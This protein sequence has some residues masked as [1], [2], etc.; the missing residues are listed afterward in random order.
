MK[1]IYDVIVVGSGAGGGISTHVLTQAGLKVLMLEAGRDYQPA[2]E[3]P[4]FQLPSAAPLRG[5]STP[6]KPGGFYDATIDGGFAVPGEP[7]TVA[8]GSQFRWWR[9]R[10][11]GGRTNHW[12]RVSLRYG[13][14]DFKSRSRDGLGS[15]WPI[16]YDDLAPWYDRVEQL[17]GVTGA[18]EGLENAPDS[19]PG[20]LL[21][22]FPL[23][24]S[25]YFVKRGF[26]S[27][28]IPVAAARLAILSR[29]YRG[30]PPCLY[31]TSCL[32]GCSIGAN[33][34]STT[35]LIPPALKSGN[36]QIRT[37]A[38]VYGVELSKRGLAKGVSFVDRRDGSHHS[39][40]GKVVVLTAST[41]ESARILLNS[42]TSAFSN[43]L[44]NES[45][46]VGRNLADTVA[47][48]IEAQFPAL[49]KL[50]P[51]N[52]D[53]TS[54]FHMYVP[55]WGYR[56]QA[57]K[58]LNF[59]RG[60]HIEP[61]GNLTMPDV[62][63]GRRADYCSTPYGM[64]LK[65]EMRQKYSSYFSFSGRGE[66]IP[67][68]KTYAELDPAVKD[69]WGIPVLRFHW[70]WSDHELRQ[71]D[72][73]R[74]TFLEV[75]ARLGGTPVRDAWRTPPAGL[76]HETGTTR[77]GTTPKDSV[78]N[79]FGQCWNIKNLFVMDGGIFVSHP[80]SPTLT[81]M[82]LSWRSSDYL[83]EQARKRNL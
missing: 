40:Q 36:L 52:D 55:W 51:R 17:I 33:F 62:S 20:T 24:A 81:I 42:R 58:E 35:V 71:A 60:Y 70:Q 78:V 19:S 49:E 57:R 41:C 39:V 65:N 3:T 11:L 43:G 23:R 56:Q 37:N 50:A 74:K 76:M 80:N 26:E 25:E 6:D 12:G 61:A 28:G 38:L 59:P 13:P 46:L 54:V 77:M 82:A 27:L 34:Q 75:I 2:T 30:R 45:G 32:R 64:A 48:H 9:A 79:Q 16:T 69:K 14:Y 63:I 1:E 29:E 83:V 10:M 47:V 44:A 21:P 4:M 8:E 67:N 73:Q 31:A 68:E 18:Y 22:P 5:A 66:M 7:Y 72:H 53:G 15:D